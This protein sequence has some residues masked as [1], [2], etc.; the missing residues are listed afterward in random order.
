VDAVARL[1]GLKIAKKE[2]AAKLA[3]DPSRISRLIAL[4]DLPP[5]LQPY[6]DTMQIDPLYE[7]GQQWKGSRHAVEDLLAREPQPTRAAI[8]ELA[9]AELGLDKGILH[10]DRPPELAPAQVQDGLARGRGDRTSRQLRAD[11]R[12]VLP[13]VSV[14]VRHADHGEGRVVQ[15]PSVIGSRLPVLYGGQEELIQTALDELTIVAID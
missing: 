10:R 14:R 1:I 7:L 2:I 9:S 13:R 12:S 3:C 11:R 4:A 5:G 15:P 6:L 8:R